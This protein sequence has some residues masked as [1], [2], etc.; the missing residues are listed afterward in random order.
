MYIYI[1]IYVYIYIYMCVCVCV[2]VCVCIIVT[3]GSVV[4]LDTNV[5]RRP[6][7]CGAAQ[8]RTFCPPTGISDLVHVRQ[9]GNSR[10]TPCWPLHDIAITNIVWCMAYKGRVG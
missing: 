5:V 9:R 7:E 1:Y 4:A 6:V 10:R 3:L 2:C 8:N